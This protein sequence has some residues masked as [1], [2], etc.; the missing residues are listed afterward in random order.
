MLV[1]IMGAKD[2][3]SLTEVQQRYKDKVKEQ[4][5][6]VWLLPAHVR[7]SPCDAARLPTTLCPL[8]RKQQS[9]RAGRRQVGRS[10]S[11]VVDCTSA[12]GM[13]TLSACC[14]LR[15]RLRVCSPPVAAPQEP[16]P[17]CGL[18]DAAVGCP[19]GCA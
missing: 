6:K 9:W 2:E 19:E 15:S 13:L 8:C 5:A 1:K 17:P 14:G 11:L 4:I 16:S 3:A 12:G 7:R 10:L 18:S